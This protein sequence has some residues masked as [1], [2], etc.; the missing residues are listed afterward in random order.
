MING[1]VTINLVQWRDEF[2]QP[3]TWPRPFLDDDWRNAVLPNHFDEA[4]AQQAFETL[5][6]VRSRLTP[7][8]ARR[9]REH[10]G[11]R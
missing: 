9:I 2:G 7:D 4:T 6:I 10:W 3:H 11:Y 8:Q 5:N 1:P